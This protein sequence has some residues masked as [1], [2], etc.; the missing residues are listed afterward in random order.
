[1]KKLIILTSVLL[2]S[3]S[4]SAQSDAMRELK[5]AHGLAEL[6]WV[7]SIAG[8][9]EDTIVSITSMAVVYHEHCQPMRSPKNFESIATLVPDVESKPN[10]TTASIVGIEISSQSGGC[11]HLK[12]FL[13][14]HQVFDWIW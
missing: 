6:K 2:M 8:Y 11:N 13:T 4:F 14:K 3:M 7:N 9:D 12:K 10:F 5:W 1:M